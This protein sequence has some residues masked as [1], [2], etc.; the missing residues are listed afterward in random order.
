MIAVT[1]LFVISFLFS[2]FFCVVTHTQSSTTYQ[3]DYHPNA[4]WMALALP[5]I[6]NLTLQQVTLPGTH[7]SGSYYLTDEL[8][9]EPPFLEEIVK[10]ADELDLPV[11]MIIDG[12]AQAQISNFYTQFLD[13]IRYVDVRVIYDTTDNL[14]K[15]HHGPVVGNKIELLLQNSQQFVSQYPS[16]VLVMELSHGNN[17]TAAQQQLLLDLI[18]KYLGQYLWP[19]ANGFQ[20]INTMIASG[21]NILLTL[22]FDPLPPNI[23]SANTIVNT[24][25]NSPDLKTM[26]AYN[27]RQA[28][29]WA[30]HGIFP[31]QLFKMSWTLTPNVDTIIEMLL[32]DHPHYLIEL[33]NIANADLNNWYNK[34]IAP[35]GFKYP[36]FGNILII[37]NYSF[38]PIIDIVLKGLKN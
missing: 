25:A 33:A 37:D 17:E 8:I 24:Y 3:S 14:W 38:S 12:W 5:I 19:R 20:T 13:G 1:K 15:T 23:W 9:G 27:V 35:A 22:E 21:K 7:D 18:Q 10:V 26:E 29:G 34:Q 6:G 32:P 28:Q 31:N 16:E 2:A 11:G 36:I 4:N 30:T